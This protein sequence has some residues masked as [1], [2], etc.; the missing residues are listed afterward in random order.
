MIDAP[1]AAYAVFQQITAVDPDPEIEKSN[2]SHKYFIDAPSGAFRALG[3]EAW[4]SGQRADSDGAEDDIEQVVF[5]NKFAALNLATSKEQEAD[6]GDSSDEGSEAGGQSTAA[7]P[8]RRKQNKPSGKG[9]K[10]KGKEKAKGKQQQPPPPANE[11]SLDDVPLE[12]Y[13]IIESGGGG[14]VTDYLMAVYDVV[15]EWASLRSYLQSL[16]SE[17]AYQGFNSAVAGAVSNVAISMVKRTASELFVDFP[18]N[19]SYET[20]MKTMTR[21]DPDKAQG[22]FSLSLFSVSPG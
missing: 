2:A 7:A 5:S 18:G 16:W 20:V 9:K 17:V 1:T 21:G 14:L 6:V 8:Q 15:S 4:K 10:G 19:D 11:P 22:M 13:R 3:G 12:S